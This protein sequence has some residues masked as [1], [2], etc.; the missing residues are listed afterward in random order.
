MNRIHERL[1][2]VCV[3]APEAQAGGGSKTSKWVDGTCLHDIDFIV[4]FG[5]LAA[6]KK[7]KVEVLNN[8][9][10][11]STNAN[12]IGT[13]EYTADGAVTGDSVIASVAVAGDRGQ[14]YAV[15][16]SNTDTNTVP[17]SVLALA[18]PWYKGENSNVLLIK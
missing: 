9:A 17:V 15:K 5:A 6:G 10:A 16:V 13:Y 12:T 11:S 1:N 3:I 7:I 18:S 4:Q 14:F 2:S 8:T